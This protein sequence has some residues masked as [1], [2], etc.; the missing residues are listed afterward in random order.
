MVEREIESFIVLQDVEY[1]R[2]RIVGCNI[3]ICTPG[4]LLQHMDETPYF[5]V[6]QLKV[7]GVLYLFLRFCLSLFFAFLQCWTKRT[8]YWI[9]AFANK[10]TQL[11]STSA[12]HNDRRCCSRRHKRSK[13]FWRISLRKDP[14]SQVSVSAG[15]CLVAQSCLR[16]GT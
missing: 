10:W 1:E 16:I 9:W 6:D 11:L 7:L 8:E 3:L 12:V 15:S 2:M 4:R 5:D 14:P 13:S